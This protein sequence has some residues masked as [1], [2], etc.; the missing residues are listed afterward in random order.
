[1]ILQNTTH[2]LDSCVAD[3]IHDTK[4]PSYCSEPDSK[5]KSEPAP[6]CRFEPHISQPFVIQSGHLT[7]TL[8]GSDPHNISRVLTRISALAKSRP[9]PAAVSIVPDV[10]ASVI[11]W[12]DNMQIS[13]DRLLTYFLKQSIPSSAILH[14]CDAAINIL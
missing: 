2:Q 4:Q 10:C 12:S 6:S 13:A 5:N 1:M 9:L 7:S 8:K 11:T 3:S 14:I